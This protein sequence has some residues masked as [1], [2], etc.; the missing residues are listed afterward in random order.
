VAFGRAREAVAAGG[1]PA[2]AYYARARH[3][4]KLRRRGIKKY[5]H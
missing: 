4:E 3:R 5:G 1:I 2:L